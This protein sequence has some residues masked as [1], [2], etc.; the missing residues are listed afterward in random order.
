MPCDV[1]SDPC[2][3]L[4]LHLVRFLHQAERDIVGV[5]QVAAVDMPGIHMLLISD[6]HANHER[7]EQ[8]TQS[9]RSI[10]V[11]GHDPID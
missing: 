10:P 6:D 7:K 11:E 1:N 5:D 2:A 8:G 3:H 9:R 4:L